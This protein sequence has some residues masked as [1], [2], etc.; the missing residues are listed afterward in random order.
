MSSE[1]R[2]FA[3]WYDYFERKNKSLAEFYVALETKDTYY[4]INDAMAG[5]DDVLYEN[6]YQ[7]GFIEKD[8]REIMYFKDDDSSKLGDNYARIA[9]CFLKGVDVRNVKKSLAKKSTQDSFA[10]I[11][12]EVFSSIDYEKCGIEFHHLM[13]AVFKSKAVDNMNEML[14]WGFMHGVKLGEVYGTDFAENKE[15]K[16]SIEKFEKEVEFFRKNG[17]PEP[18]NPKRLGETAEINDYEDDESEED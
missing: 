5:F 4:L 14:D 12:E 1:D 8:F 16:Q 11:I 15:L 13:K 2:D 7:G 18:T 9:I 17:V 10:K 6:L 3:Y